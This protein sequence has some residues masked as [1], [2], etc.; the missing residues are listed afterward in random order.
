M[1]ASSKAAAQSI[2]RKKTEDMPDSPPKRVTRARAKASSGE[3]EPKTKVTKIVTA[4]AKAAVDNKRI[5]K[6]VKATKRNAKAV[7]LKVEAAA[8]T[9]T[10]APA[11][12]E[13]VKTKPKTRSKKSEEEPIE[14]TVEIKVAAPSTRRVAKPPVEKEVHVQAP[15]PRGRPKK[16]VPTTVSKPSDAQKVVKPEPTTTTIRER[17]TATTV[18]TNPAPSSVAAPPRKRVK[19]QDESEKEK[20]NI[21]QPIAPKESALIKT[22]LKAKPVRKPAVSRT[23]TRSKKAQDEKKTPD[24]AV[25]PEEVRPLSP[26]KVKQVAKSFSIGSEDELCRER[27]PVRAMSK[28]PVKPPFSAFR[29]MDKSPTKVQFDEGDIPP[30][31]TKNSAFTILTSPARR[32]PPSPFKDS[33]KESPKRVNLGDSMAP[34][35]KNLPSPTK[36]TFLQSPPK[37]LVSPFKLAGASSSQVSNHE[38]PSSHSVVAFTEFTQ[39]KP[40]IFSPPK[41]IR[42]PLRAMR[43]PE[44]PFKVLTL[45]PMEHEPES[46]APVPASPISIES[47]EL[48]MSNSLLPEAITPGESTTTPEIIETLKSSPQPSKNIDEDSADHR[49]TT[50]E[51]EREEPVT[52]NIDVPSTTP[53]EPVVQLVAPALS[54][55]T[56]PRLSAE[57][58]DSEDEL[59]TGGR[60]SPTPR[61]QLQS[62]ITQGGFEWS[63]IPNGIAQTFSFTPLATQFGEWTASSP[64]K[65]VSTALLQPKRGIFSPLGPTFCGGAVQ[66]THKDVSESSGNGETGSPFKPSFFEDCFFSE[67]A[68]DQGSSSSVAPSPAFEPMDEKADTNE[69]DS[70]SQSFT[71]YGDENIL[72]EDL[73]VAEPEPEPRPEG[74]NPALTCTPETV[75]A[76]YPREIHTVSKVPL[77]P[78]GDDSPTK[79]PRKRSRS[80]TGSKQT[81]N[82]AEIAGTRGFGHELSKLQQVSFHTDIPESAEFSSENTNATPNKAA[83]DLPRTPASVAFSN[84]STPGRTVRKSSMSNILKGAVVFV[85]VHTSEGADASGIFL[86]LLTQMGARCVKQW[87]WNPRSGAGASRMNDHEGGASASAS[88]SDSPGNN[89][90][91]GNNSNNKIGITHVVYKDGG[92]RT[93]EK[94]REAKGVVLCVGVGWVLEYDFP[95]PFP[96]FAFSLVFLVVCFLDHDLT[97]N[98]IIAASAKINGSTKA[99]T[100]LTRT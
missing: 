69:E 8:Q 91:G 64:E 6:P 80:L 86:D 37:R 35:S 15:K 3:L 32:P 98:L 30:S 39:L 23:T 66:E 41:A 71:E 22:G 25:E 7:D 21:Q 75:F 95:F 19:F 79:L 62:K 81:A 27:T 97:F 10:E 9:I 40:L 67:I 53:P 24:H 18:K 14:K 50:P 48:D 12:E 76:P 78:A 43:S 1:G 96:F 11:A 74:D 92:K 58:S 2:K 44:N 85:D 42:S 52:T 61:A 5:A 90:N 16:V 51:I 49:T 94:V 68:A 38:V 77:K 26:K 46:T 60:G 100:P 20:E 84:F 59:V 57:E 29:D 87:H 34:I 47:P 45:E 93:L 4:S 55:G 56:T 65:S 13:P 54:F 88:D 99:N 33:L 83:V 89:S 36:A 70:L 63:P 73:V 82:G 17:A 72:P 28:S 31:P